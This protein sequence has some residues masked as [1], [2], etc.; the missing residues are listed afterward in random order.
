MDNGFL[1]VTPDESQSHGIPKSL[2]QGFSVLPSH[3]V[4]TEILYE[5]LVK[6]KLHGQFDQTWPNM[7]KYLDL[8]WSWYN[9]LVWP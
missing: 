1:R 2:M 7:T 5:F 4:A 9:F 6:L 8:Q 3:I